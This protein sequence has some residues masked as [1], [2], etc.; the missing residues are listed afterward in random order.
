MSDPLAHD[1]PG[2]HPLEE[3]FP[4]LSEDDGPA[5]Q[6]HRL[7]PST[8]G[9]LLYLAILGTTLAGLAVVTFGDWRFGV[10]WVGSALIAAAVCRLL[11]PR[12]DAGMLEVRHRF[13]DALMLG[14]VGVALIVLSSTIPN[15]PV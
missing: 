15:Q 14:A 3:G 9:G 12:R 6:Q 13:V 4:E 5:R 11:L 7:Y 1:D 10:K 8:I 2:E